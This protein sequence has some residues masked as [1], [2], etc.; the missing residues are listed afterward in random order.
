ME[1]DIEHFRFLHYSRAP[2]VTALEGYH[3]GIGDDEKV[4]FE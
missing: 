2:T 1:V 3:N 4:N